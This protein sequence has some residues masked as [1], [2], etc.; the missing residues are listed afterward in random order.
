MK[1]KNQA[2][3]GSKLNTMELKLQIYISINTHVE[4]NANTNKTL[5][6][7]MF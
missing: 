1:L 5:V 7:S 2:H 4:K 3:G 6:L